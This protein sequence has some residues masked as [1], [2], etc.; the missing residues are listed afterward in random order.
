MKEDEL[1][2]RVNKIEDEIAI[3]EEEMKILKE[4]IS[5][6]KIILDGYLHAL[7]SGNIE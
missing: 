2:K 7:Y 1:K 6:K 5:G 3:L 4:T